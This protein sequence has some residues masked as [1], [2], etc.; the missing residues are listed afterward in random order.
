MESRF[1]ESDYKNNVRPKL[2]RPPIRATVLFEYFG[3]VRVFWT[4]SSI[5]PAER[6]S[7]RIDNDIVIGSFGTFANT[8]EPGQLIVR[9]NLELLESRRFVFGQK[10]SERKLTVPSR[11]QKSTK[12][13]KKFPEKRTPNLCINGISSERESSQS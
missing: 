6:C 9:S 12:I 2:M 11:R 3:L 5:A 8:I 1:R 7:R 13:Y 10:A 4:Y